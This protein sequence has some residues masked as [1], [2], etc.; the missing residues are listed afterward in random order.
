[1]LC[2]TKDGI[3]QH[4]CNYHR[5]YKIRLPQDIK[6]TLS[7]YMTLGAMA[8][9]R[10]MNEKKFYKTISKKFVAFFCSHQIILETPIKKK[11]KIT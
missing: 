4:N 3:Y 6:D 1:M 2:S 10:F 8:Y 11:N 5:E 9:V 7:Q